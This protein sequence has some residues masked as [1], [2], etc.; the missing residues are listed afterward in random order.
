MILF[1]AITIEKCVLMLLFFFF[2]LVHKIGKQDSRFH[3]L[4]PAIRLR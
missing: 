4:I 2:L 1:F 3:Q